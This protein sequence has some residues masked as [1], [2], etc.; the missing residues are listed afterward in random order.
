MRGLEPAVPCQG[1]HLCRET[2]VELAI[3]AG[4]L[5]V[6]FISGG[7]SKILCRQLSLES[8]WHLSQQPDYGFSKPAQ[9]VS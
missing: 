9:A 4:Q 2:D 1:G 7:S 5:D 8:S 6:T 3:S